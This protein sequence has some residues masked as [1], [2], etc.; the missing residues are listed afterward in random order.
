MADPFP[1]N[2]MQGQAIAGL[3]A[4]LR[5]VNAA[6]VFYNQVFGVWPRFN[7]SVSR[8]LLTPLDSLE[9]EQVLIF[10]PLVEVVPGHE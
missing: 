5:A 10:G 8:I 2:P 3:V 1:P 4:A 9:L 7:E 6:A